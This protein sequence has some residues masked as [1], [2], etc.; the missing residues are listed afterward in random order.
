MEQIGD[1]TDT[2]EY[3]VTGTSKSFTGKSIGDYSYQVKACAGSTNCSDLTA[4]KTVTVIPTAE[5]TINGVSA[6]TC[7]IPA[8]EALCNA[9]DVTVTWSSNVS[10]ACV[11]VS[12]TNLF[13]CSEGSIQ[14]R[15]IGARTY[16]FKVHQSRS[17]DAPVL[18]SATILPTPR[19]PS[20]ITG[21]TNSM[22]GSYTLNWGSSRG[23]TMY[24]LQEM[25]G[26]GNWTTVQN[27]ATRSKSFSGKTNGKY[28]Y[29]VK[30]CSSSSFCSDWTAPHTVTVK[31]NS[32]PVVTAIANQS[33]LINGTQSVTVTVTDDDTDDTH[34]VT[35]TSSNTS[36]A[37][38]AV[39]GKTLTITG[40][41]VGSST[42]RVTATDNSGGTNDTSAE[43]SFEVTVRKPNDTPVVSAIA[44]QSVLVSGTQSVTVTVT[45]DDTDDTHTVTATSSNTSKATVAVSGKTLTI[46]GVAVGQHDQ[47]DCHG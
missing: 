34:T 20:A 31:V 21:P 43:V 16:T 11:Y 25:I 35:A 4:T 3:D 15:W 1:D 23:T 12:D 10:E 14:V 2:T 41:A 26:D 9:A 5:I 13:A 17:S 37:T 38:V 6:A 28:K 19:V 8:G 46:T 39:S 40:V 47:S 18:A 33:V 27:T 22:D 44:D 7:L 29:Q 42:I 30:A 24:T 36:K 45:D 32:T